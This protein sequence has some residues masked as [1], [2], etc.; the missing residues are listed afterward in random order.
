MHDASTDPHELH[1]FIEA[2]DPVMDT[3][4][5][6]LGQGRKQTHWMWFVFP[7]LKG[8]GSSEMAKRYAISSLAEARAFLLHPILGPRL[9]QCVQTLLMHPRASAIDI[10]GELD[11]LKLRS[12][13]TLFY[14]SAPDEALFETALH[15]FFNG[16]LDE[17]TVRS[18]SSY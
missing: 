7:Q 6:E 1:R 2:Q 11:S 10:F 15:R 18:V 16:T 14:L 17:K 12:C 3:V 9:T 4:L 8:L 5:R 13:L